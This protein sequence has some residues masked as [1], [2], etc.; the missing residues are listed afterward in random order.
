MSKNNYSIE[1]HAL[2]HHQPL[3]VKIAKIKKNI[4]IELSEPEFIKL[5]SDVSQMSHM[6]G[7]VTVSERNGINE[8]KRAKRC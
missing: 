5:T 6:P 8:T 7:N 3:Y 1:L 4:F 2:H